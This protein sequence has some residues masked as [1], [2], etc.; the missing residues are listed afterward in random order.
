MNRHS[1]S[2]MRAPRWGSL[3]SKTT[4]KK[5]RGCTDVRKAK[6][7]SNVRVKQGAQLRAGAWADH[8]T[9]EELAP[10]VFRA[11]VVRHGVREPLGDFSSFKLAKRAVALK[12][13]EMRRSGELD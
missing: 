13:N 11:F 9:V 4:A 6:T 1:T 3:R 10:G 2:R 7:M 5:I 12:L 8:K